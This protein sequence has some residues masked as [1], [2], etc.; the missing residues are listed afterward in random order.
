MTETAALIA[1][2]IDGG[3]AIA[4]SFVYVILYSLG[5]LFITKGTLEEMQD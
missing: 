4:E 3:K 1:C 2:G 5:T